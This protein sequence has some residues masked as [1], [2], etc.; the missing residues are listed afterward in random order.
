MKGFGNKGNTRVLILFD[1]KTLKVGAQRTEIEVK[2]ELT[3]PQPHSFKPRISSPLARQEPLQYSTPDPINSRPSSP[4]R[5]RTMAT[6]EAQMTSEAAEHH[7]KMANARVLRDIEII[8]E[9]KA[10]VVNASESAVAKLQAASAIEKTNNWIDDHFSFDD[11]ILDD[12][13]ALTGPE[14][15]APMEPNAADHFQ[16]PESATYANETFKELQ[17]VVAQDHL[18]AARLELM[19]KLKES[20][21]MGSRTMKD[22][23]LVENVIESDQNSPSADKDEELGENLMLDPIRDTYLQELFN[24]GNE[25]ALDEFS[26]HGE[27]A[28]DLDEIVEA[29]EAVNENA[30]YREKVWETI[31][32]MRAKHGG[33]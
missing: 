29:V 31:Q 30:A 4:V 12:E 2:M 25:H 13:S 5:L 16:V 20:H 27:E 21:P 18:S 6:D 8:K 32:M 1:N 28:E 19:K 14:L 26:D 17:Q 11:D 15:F 9:K 22:G 33:L 23:G 24:L 10:R 7:H 3:C